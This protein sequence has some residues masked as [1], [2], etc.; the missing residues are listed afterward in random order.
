M[1]RSQLASPEPCPRRGVTSVRDHRHPPATA[2]P[3]LSRQR[4]VPRSRSPVTDE[5]GAAETWIVGTAQV[6][7]S[8]AR[9][10]G[11]WKTPHYAALH[12]CN[13]GDTWCVR[14]APFAGGTGQGRQLRGAPTAQDATRLEDCMG[15][16]TRLVVMVATRLGTR[17]RTAMCVQ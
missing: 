14:L 2:A 9:D 7:K 5:A 16:A 4:T 11:E 1:P 10:C 17:N 15:G 3:N 13:P 12:E 8:L 6:E